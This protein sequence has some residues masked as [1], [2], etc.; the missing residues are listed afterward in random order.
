LPPTSWSRQA[1][2]AAYDEYR[3]IQIGQFGPLLSRTTSALV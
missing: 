3:P 1:T 2:K